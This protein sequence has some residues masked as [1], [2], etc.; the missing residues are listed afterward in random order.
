MLQ[1]L[2]ALILGSLASLLAFGAVLALL[3]T[4]AGASVPSKA[5]SALISAVLALSLGGFVVAWIGRGD[6]AKLAALFGFLFGGFSATYVLGPTWA[7]LLLATVSGVAAAGGGLFF[8][9]RFKKS[10]EVPDTG[11]G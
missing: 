9:S 11:A 10:G 4:V 7:A 5:I 3:W 8:R 6:D 1:S 2:G